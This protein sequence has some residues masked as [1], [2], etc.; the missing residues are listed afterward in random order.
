M[1]TIKQKQVVKR[2]MENN[3]N[4]SKSMREVGY[5]KNYSKN[6]Q[7]LVNSKGFIEVCNEAG[8]TEEFIIKC[9]IDDI[10]N[11]PSY[12][13]TELG[14]AAKMRGLLSDKI[15][16]TSNGKVIKGFNFIRNKATESNKSKNKPKVK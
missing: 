10:K 7:T 14:L 12:R 4:V 2:I 6:P 13:A 1:P 11:K 8:L 15:D 16:I 9:L 3:G 5:S